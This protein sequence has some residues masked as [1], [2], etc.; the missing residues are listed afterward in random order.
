MNNLKELSVEN[1]RSRMIKNAARIWGV[2][3]DDIESTFD[4]IVSMLIE[5]CAFELSKVNGEIA[6]T[7]LRILKRLAQ[8]LSP[9]TFTGAQPAFAVAHARAADP[10]TKLTPDVQFFAQQKIITAEQKEVVKDIYFSP[11]GAV[12]V[13]DT[14]IKF[15]AV[16][17]AIY[18]YRTPSSKNLL[19]EEKSGNSLPAHHVWMA[20]ECNQKIKSL[21]NFSFYFDWK[22]DPE[23]DN[24]ISLL[25]LVKW[26][27]N[28]R[29]LDCVHGI[30]QSGMEETARRRGIDEQYD[31]SNRIEKY[32]QGIFD[33]NFF[34]IQDDG[35]RFSISDLVPDE[36]QR[37]FS[38]DTI[39]KL[40]GSFVWIKLVFPGAMKLNV[41]G[42]MYISM[43][44]F[45]VIN[46]RV[47]KIT[48][49]LRSN[50][51]IVPL[52]TDEVFFDMIH[53]QN[54]EGDFF[55]SNP[56]GSGFNNEAGSYTLRYG[57][58]ERF[59]KRAATE[60]L[61]TTLDLLRDESASYSSLGNDFINTHISQI[62]QAIA[63]I[64]KRLND[65]G[66]TTN[67]SH[68]IIINP[69]KQ[70]ENV[71][72]RFWSTFGVEGNAVKAGSKLTLSSGGMLQSS[73][74]MLLST[75]TGGKK[76]LG[77]SEKITAF[78]RAILTHDRIVTQ[79]DILTFC[80]HELNN[81]ASRIEIKKNWQLSP[82]PFNG[83]TRIIEIH[84][85]P[86]QGDRISAAE[87]DD[88]ARELQVKITTH[89][90]ELIPF[91]VLIDRFN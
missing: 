55:K 60:F 61:T 27:C 33:R 87:W 29:E 63:M 80:H 53:I 30:S 17:K 86:N 44:S 83:M 75:S 91:K 72:I 40:A 59:D 66:E 45:P 76:A 58:V 85:I 65:K 90:N 2:E 25:P 38:N 19:A 52:K 4:P 74:S 39:E 64:E 41:L 88:L 3:G 36:L 11:A 50:L 22:N 69:V 49:Q 14:D 8:V 57:G 28:N 79:E 82:M 5:A 35:F 1:I 42:D 47:N 81:L 54:S 15:M 20:V 24:Y 37:V 71:F 56:L 7:Q 9:D 78:K 89:S 10:E 26:N 6:D 77:G 23:K 62:N 32:V 68:F 12:K 70:H 67:P 73:S 48:Y 21:D 46:R 31:V 51:N 84:I 43:N 34:T 13:F 18:E 16:G